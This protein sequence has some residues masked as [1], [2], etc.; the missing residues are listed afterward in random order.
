MAAL[1]LQQQFPFVDQPT[2]QNILN[3]ECNGDVNKAIPMLQK[4]NQ[5]NQA[6]NQPPSQQI[7][8]TANATPQ[9]SEGTA[10]RAQP[11]TVQVV[12]VV[13]QPMQ[14]ANNNNYIAA[15]KQRHPG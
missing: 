8:L 14:I 4:I 5:F 2:I 3:N 11:Q 9:F 13:Q 15:I 10:T 12:Q 6:M 7:P 1:Q